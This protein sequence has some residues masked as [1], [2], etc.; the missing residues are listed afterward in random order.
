MLLILSTVGGLNTNKL[1]NETSIRREVWFWAGYLRGW[2]R[3]VCHDSDRLFQT[4]WL[5]LQL[6]TDPFHYVSGAWLAKLVE[7]LLYWWAGVATPP[8]QCF[9]YYVQYGSAAHLLIY[10]WR[11]TETADLFQQCLNSPCVVLWRT[12][13]AV[14]NS[15][16]LKHSW[17]VDILCRKVFLNIL[18]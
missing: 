18:K 10:R 15:V 4:T 2:G 14:H 12:V 11:N 9:K 3:W 7:H 16:V 6:I 1:I 13:D 5:R 17:D 8:C